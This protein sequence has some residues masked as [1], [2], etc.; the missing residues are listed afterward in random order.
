MEMKLWMGPLPIRWTAAL[1]PLPPDPSR[2]GGS[3]SAAGFLDRQI[4]G[5]FRSW[6]HQHRFTA[7]GP[8]A[9]WVHDSIEA[10]LRS[11]PLWWAV[12]LV[13]W[14]GLRP[15]F[16][17]RAFRTRRLLEGRSGAPLKNGA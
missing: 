16:A 3:E 5:P 2:G 9:T 10:H 13:M 6:R 7:D 15:M 8:G 11:H 1:E 12:G 4:E 14:W 17:Y